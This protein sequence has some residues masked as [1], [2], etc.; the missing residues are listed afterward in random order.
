MVY[1]NTVNV[2]T[3]RKS[4]YVSSSD[5]SKCWRNKKKLKKTF[6]P[7]CHSIIRQTKS[8]WEMSIRNAVEARVAGQ[9]EINRE[10]SCTNQIVSSSQTKTKKCGLVLWPRV[11]KS[12][13]FKR[14]I[15]HHFSHTHTK[16]F[17]QMR[18]QTNA[19]KKSLW[20]LRAS[21]D[22]RWIEMAAWLSVAK[23]CNFMRKFTHAYRS[24]CI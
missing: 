7:S 4:S 24:L 13:D 15:F 6:P 1:L 17:K 2:R 5:H 10:F 21:A 16:H 8:P 19:K 23:W 12:F 18:W 22:N 3:P 14:N 20:I 11:R 9:W